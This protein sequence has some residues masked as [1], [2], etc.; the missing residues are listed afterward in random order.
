MHCDQLLGIARRK[1]GLPVSCPTCHKQVLVPHEDQVERPTV[2]PSQVGSSAPANH[3]PP[4][5]SSPAPSSPLLFERDDFDDLLNPP[6]LGRTT[7]PTP[8]PGPAPMR[9]PMPLTV[10]E[11]VGHIAP[12]PEAVPEGHPLPPVGIVLSPARATTLTVIFIVLLAA[13]FGAGLVVGRF[14]F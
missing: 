11:S 1:A 10:G 2:A 13:A 7:A 6:P 5:T 12:P 14:C 4:P 3:A 9:V 8:V